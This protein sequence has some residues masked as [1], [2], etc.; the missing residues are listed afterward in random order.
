MK[1]IQIPKY[2]IRYDK[3]ISENEIGIFY[4]DAKVL[5]DNGFSEVVGEIVFCRK[6]EERAIRHIFS[7]LKFK[8]K[9]TKN[10]IIEITVI[11]FLSNTLMI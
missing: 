1:T 8:P 6:N 2:K 9:T 4:C 5:F 7:N 10:I 11:K 3:Q